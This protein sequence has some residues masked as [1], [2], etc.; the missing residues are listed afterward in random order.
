MPGSADFCMKCGKSLK[1]LK[2]TDK[3]Y[4]HALS[5]LQI[6]SDADTGPL[7]Q[8]LFPSEDVSESKCPKAHVV[9][10][11]NE[12]GEQ[13]AQVIIRRYGLDGQGKRTLKA[14]AEEAGVKYKTIQAKHA[15]AMLRLSLRLRPRDW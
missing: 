15:S 8:A 12:L 4:A 5:I 1:R 9:K 7:L 6:S 14:I 10:T 11:V 3:R 2:G 13:R